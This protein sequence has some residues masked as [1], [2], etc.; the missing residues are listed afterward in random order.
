M[1]SVAYCMFRVKFLKYSSTLE[2]DI[3]SEKSLC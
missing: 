1:F 2:G 3:F